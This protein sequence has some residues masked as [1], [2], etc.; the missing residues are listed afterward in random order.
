MHVLVNAVYNSGRANYKLKHIELQIHMI[1]LCSGIE[2]LASF[3]WPTPGVCNLWP[4]G[5][6]WPGSL[7]FVARGKI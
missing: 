5:Q 3:L 2:A 4:A 1:L 6:K 7:S